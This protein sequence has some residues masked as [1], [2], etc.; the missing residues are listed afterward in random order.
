MRYKQPPF[1]VEMLDLIGTSE[2][3]S[4][5]RLSLTRYAFVKVMGTIS[6][7][8]PLEIFKPPV[9]M[10]DNNCKAMDP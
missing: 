5:T 1:G 4:L 7:V 6:M 10:V 8:K 9:D 3:I 2:R